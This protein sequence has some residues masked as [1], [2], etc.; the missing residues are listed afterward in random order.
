[1]FGIGVTEII[2]I[3]VVA[4]VIVGPEKLPELAKTIA[5]GFNEFKRTTNDLKRS[6]EWNSDNSSRRGR[7]DAPLSA[8]SDEEAD[9]EEDAV[10]EDEPRKEPLVPKP[11]KSVKKTASA[12]KPVTKKTS[13]RKRAPAGKAPARKVS[14]RKAPAGRAPARKKKPDEGGVS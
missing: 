13:V 1:M 9:V 6:F 14:T 4:L 10:V 12:G 8:S 3:L 11:K 7:G 2:L 5:K